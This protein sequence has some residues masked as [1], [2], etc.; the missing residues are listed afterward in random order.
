MYVNVHSHAV[1]QSDDVAMGN[2]HL[3]MNFRLNLYLQGIV[4]C[5]VRQPKGVYMCM[6]FTYKYRFSLCD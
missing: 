5:H 6:S 4:N 2:H 1:Q 3:Y